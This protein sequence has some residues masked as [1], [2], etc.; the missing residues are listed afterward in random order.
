MPRRTGEGVSHDAVTDLDRINKRL[1]M[2]PKEF[3]D[4]EQLD[5]EERLRDKGGIEVGEK[6]VTVKKH[7]VAV[8]MKKIP[9]EIKRAT[10][11]AAS[12]GLN[13]EEALLAKEEMELRGEEIGDNVKEVVGPGEV[14][15]EPA[16]DYSNFD[17]EVTTISR[18]IQFSPNIDTRTKKEISDEMKKRIISEKEKNN[19]KARRGKPDRYKDRRQAESTF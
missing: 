9:G 12:R 7:G 5:E 18:N 14:E 2:I 4:Q 17:S 19:E 16:G 3:V 10:S 8:D 1:E 6:Y 11:E 13:P 15:K